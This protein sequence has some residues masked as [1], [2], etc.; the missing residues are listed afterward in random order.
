MSYRPK[1]WKNP[2]PSAQFH[3]MGLFYKD[4]YEAGAD[5]MLEALRKTGKSYE[6]ERD[7]GLMEDQTV[8]LVYVRTKPP[9]VVVF[10]PDED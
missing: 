10:I 3:P 6:S 8:L 2:Y 4:A 1:G 5:A 7:T 9:G